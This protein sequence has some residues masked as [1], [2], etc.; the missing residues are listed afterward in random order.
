MSFISDPSLRAA[1]RLHERFARDATRAPLEGGLVVRR[2]NYDC[3][4]PF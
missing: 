4:D 3:I 2:C 1:S